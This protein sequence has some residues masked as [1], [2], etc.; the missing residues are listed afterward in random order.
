MRRV[1]V[2]KDLR[3]LRVYV[4]GIL[5][6]E[7]L[8]DNYDGLQAWKEG[9]ELCTYHIEFYRKRGKPVLCAYE[10]EDLWREILT[11]IVNNT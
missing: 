2:S 11:E 7:L 5:H 10:N 8:I 4:H 3:V 9:S 6:L 1:V